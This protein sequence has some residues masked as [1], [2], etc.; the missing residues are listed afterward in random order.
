M[1]RGAFLP[2]LVRRAPA[3]A[4][5]LLL[6][7]CAAV[8]PDFREPRVSWLDGWSGGTLATLAAEAPDKRQAAVDEW[9][10]HFDDP[11]L[12]QLVAEA[13]RANYSVRTAGMR[14]LEARAQLGIATSLLYPQQQ[15]ITASVVRAGEKQSSGPDN[16]LTAYSAGFA[17]GWE[18][19]FWGKFRRGVEAADANY[20]ATLA[21]YDDLQVLMAAQ[22]A[23]FYCAIRTLELRLKI[24]HENAA[25]QKRSLEITE[26]L[27]KHGSDSELDVQQAKAQYL[28][29]LSTLPQLEGSLRQTQNALS[30]LLARP[31]GPLPE[32]SAGTSR[33]PVAAL[34]AIADIPADMLRR[35][36][37]VRAAEMRLA[38][39]SALIGVSQ[40]ELYPS[41]FLIGSLGISATSISNAPRTL[42]WSI[43][44]SLVWNVFDYGRLSNQVLVQDAR[45]QQ[46]YEQYQET[47]LQA[48]R[49]VDDAAA[50]FVANREQLPI[51]DGA[52]KAAQRSLA[53]ATTQYREGMTGFER[54]LDSQ[55]RLFSQQE[56][57][58]ATLGNAAQSLVALYKAMGGG[59]QPGRQRPLV[60]DATRETMGERSAWGQLLDTPLPPANAGPQLINSERKSDERGN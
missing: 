3:S 22:V 26:R 18:I 43:G 21:Q 7:G 23:N 46:L 55:Q 31:P 36:P 15:Q 4:V 34:A 19:D 1:T 52:V 51:L 44:P 37:D 16:V 49:E 29:T 12:D 57:Q 45:F 54:V 5:A 13:Q 11:V 24:A 41:L 40:A 58:V 59:W 8:G 50:G 33:I 20:F 14:I 56:R 30:V 35:R 47:V 28:G 9:W 25:L 53:I 6:A 17:I 32:M 27:F 42:T 2:G 48:A 38:A 60:D 10:R 39:Q